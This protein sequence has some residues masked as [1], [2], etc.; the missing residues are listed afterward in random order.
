VPHPAPTA[1]RAPRRD[2]TILGRISPGLGGGWVRLHHN[3]HLVLRQV[4]GFGDDRLALRGTGELP[5]VL[6]GACGVSLFQHGPGIIQHGDADFGDADV[7]AGFDTDA[8]FGALDA[9]DDGGFEPVGE[10]KVVGGLPGAGCQLGVDGV[11][12]GCPEAYLVA[13]R[14]RSRCAFCLGLAL[15]FW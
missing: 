5:A 10:G 12:A 4:P 11:D 3:L 13:C 9:V 1:L 14:K 7:V 2:T 6:S 8:S 15:P